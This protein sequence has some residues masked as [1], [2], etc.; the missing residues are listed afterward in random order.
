[1]RLA[2]RALMILVISSSPCLLIVYAM[3]G[4]RPEALRAARNLRAS[5][6]ECRTVAVETVRVEERR[7]CFLERHSV[8]SL[9]G[10]RLADIPIEHLIMYIL[11][12]DGAQRRDISTFREFSKG[13][14]I[15]PRAETRRANKKAWALFELRA[16]AVRLPPSAF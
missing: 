11:N 12:S 13:G 1:L 16:Y 7:G 10:R 5:T 15:Q 4:T 9:I 6:A 14:S 8:L 2:R 3:T